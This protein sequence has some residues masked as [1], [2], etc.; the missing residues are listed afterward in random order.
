LLGCSG[1]TEGAMVG[2]GIKTCNIRG[3]GQRVGELETA[4]QAGGQ[5]PSTAEILTRKDIAD[6]R[7]AAQ[8]AGKR[9]GVRTTES[10]AAGR[11]CGGIR[12]FCIA[13]DELLNHQWP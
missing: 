2:A 13:H 10:A 4:V 8:R 11:S 5:V 12:Q 1:S 7:S 9:I 6:L 3:G